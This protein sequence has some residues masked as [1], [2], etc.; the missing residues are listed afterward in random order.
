MTLVYSTALPVQNV[1]V[2]P[3]SGQVDLA[4][5]PPAGDPKPTAYQVTTVPAT[6]M[7]SV[8]AGSTKA[9]VKGLTN[10]TSYMF[11]VVAVYADGSKSSAATAGPVSPRAVVTPTAPEKS[12]EC[13]STSDTYTVPGQTGVLYQVNGATTAPGKHTTNGAASVPITAVATPGYRLTGATTW[14]LTF[15]KDTCALTATPVPRLDDTTPVVGQTLTT[16]PGTWSPAP[17]VLSYQWFRALSVVQGRSANHRCRLLVIRRAGS[18]RGL[19]V[20]GQGDRNQSRLHD[21][22]DDVG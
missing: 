1:T 20:D 17:V 7:T 21:D 22:H 5:T 9:T 12:D 19:H 2:T 4:W 13:G 6:M 14:T 18:R 8:P 11:S 16:A 15:S 10:G 3:G